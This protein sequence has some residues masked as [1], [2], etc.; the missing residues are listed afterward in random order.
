[1]KKISMLLVVAVFFLT[2]ACAQKAQVPVQ[3]KQAFTQKF[4]TAKKAKWDKENATEWEVEFKM[5]HQEY[6]A[7]FATDGTWKETEYEI[8]KSDIPTAVK[9]TLNTDFTG[10]DIEEVEVSE[11][12]EGKVYEFALEKG[13]NDLE[14]A[15]A[16]DGSVVKK[17]SKKEDSD[18]EGDED[19]ENYNN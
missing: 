13:E 11:T 3:V 5:N 10:Y 16:P 19:E 7:N 1:M 8:K 12:P 2:Q 15:I 17:E 18:D 14:V 6:S 4:P 9:Q